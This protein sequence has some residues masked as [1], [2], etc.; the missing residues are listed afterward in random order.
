MAVELRGLSSGLRASEDGGKRIA[1]YAAVYGVTTQIGGPLS[2]GSGFREKIDPRAFNACLGSN[3]DIRCLAQH[4]PSQILGRTKSG[5]LKVATNE[6]GLRYEV[7]LPDSSLGNTIYQA[8]KRGDISGSSFGFAARKDAWDHE[9][10]TR[11]LLDCELF[12]CGPVTFP[13]TQ[14]TTVSVR[15]TAGTMERVAIG[16]YRTAG[17]LRLPLVGEREMRQRARELRQETGAKDDGDECTCTCQACEDDDCGNCDC[18][19]GCNGIGCESEDGATCNCA[20][21][22]QVEGRMRPAPGQTIAPVDRI[23]LMEDALLS[24]KIWLAK[25]AWRR[26]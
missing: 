21:T 13:A 14:E 26:R 23:Q 6:V 10:N 5:T 2:A 17:K 22:R 19:A 12:D 20:E 3:P 15:N 4:D 7:K 11:T 8:V 16:W 1:G 25:K 24:E 18:E 9:T